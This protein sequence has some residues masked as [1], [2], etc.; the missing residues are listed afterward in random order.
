MLQVFIRRIRPLAPLLALAAIGSFVRTSP[1]QC[2]IAPEIVRSSADLTALQR[3]AVKAFVSCATPGLSAPEPFKIV[4][5]RQMLLEPLHDP[6]ASV[7]F[8]LELSKQLEAILAGLAGDA[9]DIV[10]INALL[11]AGELATDQ[12]LTIAEKQLANPDP[13]VRYESVHSISLS[14]EAVS[15]TAPALRAER[16]DRALSALGRQLQAEQDR[17]VIDALARALGTGVGVAA[18]GLESVRA[19][20]A[21]ELSIRCGARLKA[22]AGKPLDPAL[23]ETALTAGTTVR[24]ALAGQAGANRLPEQAITDACGLAGDMLASIARLLTDKNEPLPS[25]AGGDLN[26]EAAAKVQ[27]RVLPSQVANVAETILSIAGIKSPVLDNPTRRLSDLLK[28]AKAQDDAAFLDGVQQLVGPDGALHKQRG[29]P[30]ER[31]LP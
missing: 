25:I 1:G 28:T 8:R 24:N 16:L 15:R 12:G 30:P 7:P 27:A 31:F 20:A 5:A 2:Q 26:E 18:P 14:F 6:Q 10:A 29:F 13:A 4:Q 11:V 19:R 3:D 9:R 23:L 22:L 17:H 21:S